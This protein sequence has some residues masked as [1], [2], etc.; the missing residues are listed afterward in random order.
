MAG[1]GEFLKFESGGGSLPSPLTP[2]KKTMILILQI[3]MCNSCTQT[4]T[5]L[6][7]C[8]M[9]YFS[10]CLFPEKS[11]QYPYALQSALRASLKKLFVTIYVLWCVTHSIFTI[12]KYT[13][14][15][16]LY[17]GILKACFPS[18]AW[19]CIQKCFE[20]LQVLCWFW[21]SS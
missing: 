10:C 4:G 17:S 20:N 12:L 21:V 3:S 16:L 9:T 13:K 8:K 2:L 14:T 11:H 1:E 6:K 15:V 19:V 5:L 18:E 7:D